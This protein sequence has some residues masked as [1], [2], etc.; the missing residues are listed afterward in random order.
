M[1]K[2]RET[3]LSDFKLNKRKYEKFRKNEFKI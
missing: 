1:R 3:I 2:F